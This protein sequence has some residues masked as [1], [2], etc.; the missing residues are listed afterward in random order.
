MT[1]IN[2]Q[3]DIFL[4]AVCIGR[5]SAGQC[6]AALARHSVAGAIVSTDYH[7]SYNTPLKDAGVMRHVKIASDT[8]SE[9]VINMVNSLHSRFKSFM[10]GFKG[11]STKRLNNY[12]ILFK[13]RELAK[14][15]DARALMVNQMA[16]GHYETT[17]R[18]MWNTPYP[19]GMEMAYGNY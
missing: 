10:R 8:R 14:R 19:F 2:E 16:N 18:N 5:M 12:L 9:G 15:T 6:G 1:G 4:D 7:P 17:W 3:G 11:V 13:W